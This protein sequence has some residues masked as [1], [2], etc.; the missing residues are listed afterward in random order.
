[1]K[2]LLVGLLALG[3]ISAFANQETIILKC[4]NSLNQKL[5][6]E[7][8]ESDFVFL[9]SGN[10]SLKSKKYNI[11]TTPR[12][13]TI[14]VVDNNDDDIETGFYECDAYLKN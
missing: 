2:K 8:S 7:L 4:T 11:S 14:T 10:N 3:S 1:M 6:L 5:E 9:T 13:K 12:K